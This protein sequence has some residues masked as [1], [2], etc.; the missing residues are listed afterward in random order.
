MKMMKLRVFN[1]MV[2]PTLIH[3]CETWTMQM[4][5]E[6]KGQ[7]CEMIKGSSSGYGER[8]AKKVEGENGRNK[9]EQTGEVSVGRRFEKRQ[10]LRKTTKALE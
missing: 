3:G 4:K 7:A 5:H 10:T 6:S 9:G 1:A 2:V 8:E